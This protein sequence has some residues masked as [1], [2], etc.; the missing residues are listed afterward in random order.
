MALDDSVLDSTKKILNVDANYDAFDQ[1]VITF[2][3]SAFFALKRIGIVP[4]TGVR[5]T[6]K[7]TTWESLFPQHP[8]LGAIQTYVYLR[9]RLLFDPPSTPAHINAARE[10][11]EELEYQLL[12]EE[13]IR[14][15]TPPGDLSRLP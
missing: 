8:D 4:V 15:W 13:N 2:I 7:Q 3:N 5:I 9:V 11:R 12:T 6:D 1:D 14:N 10:Q